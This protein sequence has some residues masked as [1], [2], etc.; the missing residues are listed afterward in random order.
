[1]TNIFS[2][3]IN[4]L[5]TFKVMTNIVS[6]QANSLWTLKMINFQW[7]KRRETE[8]ERELWA[9]SNFSATLCSQGI[10]NTKYKLRIYKLFSRNTKYQ[11]QL[12]NDKWQIVKLLLFWFGLFHTWNPNDKCCF[13]VIDSL[14]PNFTFFYFGFAEAFERL[15]ISWTVWQ[16]NFQ[17]I[18]FLHISYNIHQIFLSWCCCT[19]V[20]SDTQNILNGLTGKL[21]KRHLPT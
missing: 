2:C 10:R 5:W 4:N 20:V 1:M 6:C 21:S 8:A 13:S 11:K 18:T 15:Q 16:E 9:L 7:K 14:Y 17:C 3:Q 19:W 12:T